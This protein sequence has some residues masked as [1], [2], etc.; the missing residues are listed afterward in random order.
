MAAAKFPDD[1][2]LITAFQQ[3]RARA[4]DER[5]LFDASAGRETGRLHKPNFQDRAKEAEVRQKE[6]YKQALL[7]ALAR[8]LADPVYAARY[9]AFGALLRTAQTQAEQ[10]LAAA[11]ASVIATRTAL[12]ALEDGANRLPDGS[13]VFRAA[14]G[15]IVDALWQE[16]D[17]EAAA[18][19]VW[20]DGASGYED[21]LATKH[22]TAAAWQRLEEIRRYRIDVLGDARD[23]WEDENTPITMD[24]MDRLEALIK[25]QQPEWP[26]P[27]P[28]PR[29]CFGAARVR[30]HSY[31]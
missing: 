14:D 29:R 22:Q 9:E 3:A 15:R 11:E 7:T 27:G 19:I 16:I 6:R 12:Q 24:E 5:D 10:A 4:Q 17:A 13:L 28:L 8:M 1:F 20:K 30:R 21:Y 25:A 23:R 18:G 31:L 2:E 26:E